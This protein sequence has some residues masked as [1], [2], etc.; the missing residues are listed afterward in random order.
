MDPFIP[1]YIDGQ[2][3]PSSKNETFEVH[4]PQSNKV[5]GISAS[6]S[7]QD[8]KDA[9]EAAA[10]A[11]TTWEHVSLPQR[12]DIF[13]KAA[14][15]LRDKYRD[16]VLAAVADE[17]AALSWAHIDLSVSMGGPYHSD[18]FTTLSPRVPTGTCDLSQVL[19]TS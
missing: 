5:V 7:S 6:A 10:R 18:M 13:I 19:L 12:R 15:I 17:I 14:D 9:V 11:F 4:N 8:C 1:L 2:W 3:R 16:N